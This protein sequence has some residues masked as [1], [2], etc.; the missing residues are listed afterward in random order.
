MDPKGGST[1]VTVEAEE[2]RARLP[3]ARTL[4]A[5]EEKALRMRYGAPVRELSTPLPR[6]HG[7]NEEL[8]DELLL[9]EMQL[10]RAWKARMAA[11]PSRPALGRN[12][13]KDKIV[14]SLRKKR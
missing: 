1:T 9:I 13:A 14:R 4:T 8:G 2:V 3:H 7:D 5:E 6:A 10:L 11:P 12:A